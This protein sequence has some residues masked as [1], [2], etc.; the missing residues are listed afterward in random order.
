[1]S[2]I[3]ITTYEFCGSWHADVSVG[4]EVLLHTTEAQETEE[5]ARWAAQDWVNR[6]YPNA[7]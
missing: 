4:S 1:M 5:H 3:K 2:R 6:K 7:K